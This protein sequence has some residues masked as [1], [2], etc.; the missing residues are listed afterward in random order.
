MKYYWIIKDG[1]TFFLEG[2]NQ[3]PANI[4]ERVQLLAEGL[5]L[6]ETELREIDSDL[7]SEALKF[8][9]TL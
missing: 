7:E 8:P 3:F 4:V 1:K 6:I 2:K 9:T 5:G